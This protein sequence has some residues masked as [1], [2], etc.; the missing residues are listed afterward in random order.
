MCDIFP[1]IH[2]YNSK[3]NLFGG[4]LL[5]AIKALAE[6]M[7][8]RKKC[9]L[10]PY[11]LFL[12]AGASISSGCSSM[13]S[14]VDK[15]LKSYDSVQ[16]S[17]W[18]SEVEQAFLVNPEYGELLRDKLNKEKQKRFY[19]IWDR[20][21]SANR[22][23]ILVDHLRPNTPLTKGYLDLAYLIQKGYFRV[24]LSTNLDNLLEKAL[25]QSSWYDLTISMYV[26]M[27]SILPKISNINWTL[28]FQHSN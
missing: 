14:I 22:Y 27:A 3:S 9:G 5:E 13:A 4:R 19:E 20:L 23:S 7:T 15:V 21:D 18:Q 1:A 6:S 8:A 17:K 2:S 24:A 16:H 10:E 25:H 26:L 28:R 11:V 12:G